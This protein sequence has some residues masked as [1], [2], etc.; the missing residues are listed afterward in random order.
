METQ[1]ASQILNFQFQGITAGC[2]DIYYY[3]IDCQWID[4]TDLPIGR[5]LGKYSIYLHNL[6][7][8]G[9]YSFKMAI[10]P[11]YK[12]PETT[13]ENNAALCTLHYN[14]MQAVI[15]NCSLVRP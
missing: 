9:T 1:E 4:I 14:E 7:F 12:I 13:F 11:E 15:N 6:F 3:N 8:S 10:N 2:K 5:K